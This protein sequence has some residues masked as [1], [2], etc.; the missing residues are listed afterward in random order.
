MQEKFNE[1]RQSAK[2][3]LESVTSSREL[4]DLKVKYV[5][6]NDEITA[7]LRGM[8]DIPAE[9]RAQFGKMVN[10]LK[11]EVAGY[12]TEKETALKTL[13]LEAKLKSEEVDVTLP[14]KLNTNGSLHPLNIVKNKIFDAFCGMGFE[15]FEG[16]EIDTDYYCF[17][18]LNI[19]KDHPARDMQDTFYCKL[20][21]NVVLR[22]QT[23]GAQI[24][25]MEMKKPPLRIISPGRVYRCE[26][27]SARK[28]IG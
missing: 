16:P 5:G 25:T 8:K 28:R 27:V 20:A 13:E 1:L 19:P 3:E 15:I 21:S 18:A 9:N 23:S 7:L 6:K 10:D 4:N 26:S 24:H 14:G 2:K 22:S 17:Q 12:F 11:E